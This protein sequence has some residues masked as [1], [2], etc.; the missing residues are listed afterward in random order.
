M[1]YFGTVSTGCFSESYISMGLNVDLSEM[2]CMDGHG[3]TVE[4][5][6]YAT[7]ESQGMLMYYEGNSRN[8][9]EECRVALESS[10]RIISQ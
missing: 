3:W 9:N 6:S 8:V 1:D 2:Q 7:K 10:V 5:H 4:T